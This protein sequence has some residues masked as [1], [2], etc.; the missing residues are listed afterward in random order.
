MAERKEF[1]N[2]KYI[3]DHSCGS[4]QIGEIDTLPDENIREYIRRFGEYGYE[5]IRNFAVRMLVCADREIKNER[6]LK[7]QQGD[8][9]KAAE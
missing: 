1:L 2:I 6:R 3:S 9:M 4:Y 8:C 5:E 7:Q